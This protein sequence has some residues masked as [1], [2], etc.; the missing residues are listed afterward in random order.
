MILF[1]DHLLVVL[2][3]YT[4]LFP[5]WDADKIIISLSLCFL[6]KW[7]AI[8]VKGRILWFVVS[9]WISG[10]SSASTTKNWASFFLSFI[11]L[12]ILPPPE[13]W[14]SGL[15]PHPSSPPTL[16]S[17]LPVISGHPSPSVT[18]SWPPVCFFLSLHPLISLS[19]FSPSSY[20]LH[21]LQ[22]ATRVSDWCG[23]I[24]VLQKQT[25]HSL[26]DTL[27]RGPAVV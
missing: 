21:S 26:A 3:L 9:V 16:S 4:V 10:S 17:S 24:S 8:Q 15:P 19:P 2:L 25:T 13:R 27:S 6:T 7:A 20:L 18:S 23:G 12:F 5:L 14:I 11:P 1:W 22:S